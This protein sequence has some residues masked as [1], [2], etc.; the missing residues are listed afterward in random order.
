MYLV[1]LLY[2]LFVGTLNDLKLG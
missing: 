1:R 2:A